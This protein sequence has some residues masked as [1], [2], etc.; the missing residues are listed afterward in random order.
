MPEKLYSALQRHANA[1]IDVAAVMGSWATQ[2]GY[3]VITVNVQDNRKDVHI[4]QR[5]FLLRNENHTD[6]T[7]WEVPLNYATSE[8]NANFQNTQKLFMLPRKYGG[9]LKLNLQY[10][11]DWIIFNVQQTGELQCTAISIN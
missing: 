9:A 7:K 2:S 3:P 8:E 10:E 1:D 6:E 4:T 11:I 5:R